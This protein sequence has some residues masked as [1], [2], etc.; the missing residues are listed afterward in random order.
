MRFF[1]VRNR[2]SRPESRHLFCWRHGRRPPKGQYASGQFRLNIGQ[3]FGT[4]IVGR[5]K[6]IVRR[7]E[8]VLVNRI[9]TR[10]GLQSFL[11]LV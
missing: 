5:A 3:F 8:F 1:D 6:L 4:D 2:R 9:A 7:S 10:N 11:H